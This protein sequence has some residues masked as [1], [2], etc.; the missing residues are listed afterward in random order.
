[1]RFAVVTDELRMVDGNE[2]GLVVELV[3]DRIAALS[4][5]FVHQMLGLGDAVFRLVDERN[6]DARP[7]LLV[8]LLSLRAKRADLEV[9]A[10]YFSRRLSSVSP[11]RRS[12]P[13]LF[14]VT[15]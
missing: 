7:F 8:A 11:A 12:D 6:L 14:P 3:R 4:H 1:M 2:L 10:A 15:L 9:V 13:V 5:H